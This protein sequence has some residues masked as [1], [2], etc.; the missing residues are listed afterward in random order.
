[1]HIPKLKIAHQLSLLMAGLV[2]L[3]VVVVGGLTVW[4]LQRGFSEYLRLRDDEQLTRL[5]QLVE[6]RAARD[7]SMDWLRGNRQ[8]MRELMDELAGREPRDG[9]DGRDN[10]PQRERPPPGDRPPPADGPPP[11]DRPPP[12]GDRPGPGDDPQAPPPPPA[13]QPP[14]PQ[15]P[16]PQPGSLQQRVLIRDAQGRR[17]AGREAP[18]GV[19]VAV[20]EVKVEGVVVATLELLEEAKPE[21]VDARFLQR[22][23][24]GLTTAAIGTIMAALLAALWIGGRWSRPLRAL[25]AASQRIARGDLSV[26]IP[27]GRAPGA[28]HSGAV[29]I[30]GLIADVNAMAQSLAA[31]ESARSRWIA[32][33]SHELRT[34]LAVLRGEFESIEDGARQP[35]RE[36]MA[37][38]REEVMQLTRLVEDLHLLA[39]ADIGAMPCE[40]V[41]G[42]A[43]EALQ[44]IARRFETRATQLGLRMEILSPG[45]PV[46]VQW[47]FGRIEQLLSNLLENCLRYTTAPGRV[48]VRWQARAQALT[49]V[50]EDSPPGV[51]SEHLSRMFAPLFR[52]DAARGRTGQQGSGLGLSIVQAIVR[53]HRGSVTA[54]PSSLGGVAITV[55]LPLQPQRLERRKSRA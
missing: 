22:Q 4:N 38:L 42:D 15:P 40:M 2:V 29:E 41:S 28:L 37:S 24:A 48:R 21:G 51:A 10:R 13:F 30:D 36:V 53:A 14:P 46:L 45:T 52:V 3:A 18:A 26:H 47:D 20:R 7:T 44:R 39:V 1:M 34:P 9:R 8:A 23:Y 12:P 33:I 17:L 32:E 6:R 11:N 31:L 5:V 25:Q 49:L 50:V 35:T 19:R 43:D 27:T 16:G 55:E 54:K